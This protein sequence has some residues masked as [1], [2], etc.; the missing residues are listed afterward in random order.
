MPLS[1]VLALLPRLDAAGKERRFHGLNLQSGFDQFIKLST[2]NDARYGFVLED[3]C[4]LGAE[5][6]V[7][8]ER[9]RG[10]GE[11]LSMTKDPTA[12]KYAWKIVM[13]SELDEK[14]QE[15]QIFSTGDHQWK[16]VLYPKGKGLGMGTHLSLYLALDLATLPAGCRVYADYTLRLVDQV[17]SRNY[18]YYRKAKS[19][20]GASSSENGWQYLFPS[21]Y[22]SRDYLFAK[23]I[24]IIEA[25]VIVIGIGSPF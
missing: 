9:S 6:F 1:D 11:V 15:S 8:G 12:S 5:V 4:V 19:W 21:F 3:T 7:C 13:F 16:M 25:E 10:K 23:D 14:R 22:Q 24:C 20:F 17:Y 18:D 2:F